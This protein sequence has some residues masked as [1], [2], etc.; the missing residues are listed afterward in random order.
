MSRS[1]RALWRAY[2]QEDRTRRVPQMGTARGCDGGRT[3]SDGVKGAIAP[4]P[5]S[6][7][8]REPDDPDGDDF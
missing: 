6:A 8:R 5:G 3:Q 4:D 2:V 7:G 1:R